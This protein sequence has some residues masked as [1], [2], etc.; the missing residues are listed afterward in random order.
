M[1]EFTEYIQLKADEILSKAS[2]IYQESFY[3]I[4]F[5]YDLKGKFAGMYHYN[6][7][8][9]HTHAI[10]Y[11]LHLCKHNQT[12]F[13]QTIAHEIAHYVACKMYGKVKSHGKEWKWVMEELGYKPLRTHNY[14]NIK[15][16]RNLKTFI[17]KCNCKEHKFTTI[18][19]N[20][21]Q[22]YLKDNKFYT[23]IKCKGN[24]ILKNYLTT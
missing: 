15:P 7:Y 4:H 14:K 10:R 9:Y 11:N 20:R 21:A 5:Y 18:R 19:H 1:C 12:A 22:R 16:G 23:C 8:R 3:D 17:Y 2:D 6:S 24:I 13:D